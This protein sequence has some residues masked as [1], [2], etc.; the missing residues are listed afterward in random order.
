LNR[1]TKPF[2]LILVLYL[3]FFQLGTIPQAKGEEENT[4]QN[5]NPASQYYL[6]M[7]TENKLMMKVNVWGAVKNPGSQYVPD[8][9]DLISLLSV[10]GGPLEDAKLSQVRLIRNFDGENKNLVIN[11]NKCLRKNAADKI[12]EI[13]PGDTVI[14]PKKGHSLGRFINILYN[15]AVITSVVKLMTD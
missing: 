15:V 7:G 5:R 14:V 4:I 11:I 9:T 12:P 8:E 3:I 2:S 6:E 10:A 13:K 1:M